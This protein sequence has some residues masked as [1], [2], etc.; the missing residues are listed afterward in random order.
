MLIVM[1]LGFVVAVGAL[2][3]PAFRTNPTSAP[4]L[5]LILTVGLIALIGLFAFRRA[6]TPQGSTDAVIDM[7]DA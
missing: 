2:A 3:Y 6:E 7:L 1:A 4:G 5:I